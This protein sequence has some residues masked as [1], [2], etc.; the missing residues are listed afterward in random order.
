[1]QEG[2]LKRRLGPISAVSITVG[3][4][5]G[6]GIFMKPLTIAH[7]VPHEGAIFL[8]WAGLGL[9]CLFGA[10]A[11]AELGA[12]LPQAGGQYAFLREAYGA[13]PAFLYGWAFFWVINCGT[14]AALAVAFGENLSPLFGIGPDALEFVELLLALAMILLLAFANHFGVHVG[15]AVQNLSTFAKLIAL[16]LLVAGGFA[17]A[18][19]GTSA[20][21]LGQ[22]AAEPTSMLA[23]FVAAAVAI[24]WAYE[25][26]YQLP[27]NAAELKRPERDLPR[28]LI[29][30]LLILIAVYLL[31]NAVYLHVVPLEEMLRIPGDQEAQVPRLT[32]ERIFAPGVSSYLSVLIA[33]SVLGAANP[34]LLS[35]PRA[36]YAMAQDRL[37][38]RRLVHVH[39]VHG[40]P[41]VSIWVQAAIGM[42]W[43]IGWRKFEYI[44]NAVVFVS[45]IFYALTVGAV[46]VLR[47]R[48]PAAA[49]PYRCHGYPWAPLVF[50]AVAV[51][52]VLQM[53]LDPNERGNALICLAILAVGLPVYFVMMVRRGS[54]PTA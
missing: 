17:L 27:F 44:T 7:N 9:V 46:F 32:V 50:M 21:A 10:F 29:L 1:M 25:G 37:V 34:N 20:S 19:V 38:P 22:P 2:Q 43:V 42:L 24:F 36:F 31:V 35:S 8:L 47:R 15:A 28:G 52:V 5:I 12:M 18:G 11:Y 30:G 48:V 39:P 54:R 4:V 13:F 14:L 40:T 33:I 23:G 26:W 51:F 16:G 45:L 41:T 53:L 6:S 3:A 49:R